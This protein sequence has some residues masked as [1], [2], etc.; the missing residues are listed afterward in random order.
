MIPTS[1]TGSSPPTAVVGGFLSSTNNSPM[2][3]SNVSNNTSTNSNGTGFQGNNSALLGI[4]SLIL[5]GRALAE[6]EYAVV[7]KHQ[8]VTALTYA[9][10]AMECGRQSP[11][12]S[13]S[14][15]A[16]FHEHHYVGGGGV[17]GGNGSG[18]VM[19]SVGGSSG[20]GAGCTLTSDI[21]NYLRRKASNSPESSHSSS[22]LLRDYYSNSSSESASSSVDSNHSRWTQKLSQL[23]QESPS[24]QHHQVAAREQKVAVECLRSSEPEYVALAINTDAAN[25]EHRRGGDFEIIRRIA[26]NRMNIYNSTSPTGVAA[27]SGSGGANCVSGLGSGG[28]GG[29]NENFMCSLQSLASNT[30]LR[31]GT[32][33]LANPMANSS[34]PKYSTYRV[35]PHTPRFPTPQHTDVSAGSASSCGSISGVPSPRCTNISWNPS[36]ATPMATNNRDYLLCKSSTARIAIPT[37]QNTPPTNSSTTSSSN[38]ATTHHLQTKRLYGR[39]CTAAVTSTPTTSRSATTTAT[40]ATTT[41][42]QGPHCDQFLRKMGLAKGDA[43]ETEEHHCDMSYVNITVSNILN[44]RYVNDLIC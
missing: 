27:S 41:P 32:P 39:E 24:A 3:G 13:T 31:V 6:D 17:A 1:F 10:N 8:D 26:L 35:S 30:C 16:A 4:A 11:K 34:T 37:P 20:N 5:E 18:G 44:R 28:G 40:A 33:I 38:S 19:T 42:Q 9:A 14:R 7:A 36:Q 12:P 22:S 43:S 15:A 2:S 21:A 25:D 23:R 29:S